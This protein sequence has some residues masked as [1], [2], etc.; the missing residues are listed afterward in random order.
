MTKVN[1]WNDSVF[2]LG[3]VCNRCGEEWVPGS[4][5]CVSCEFTDPRIFIDLVRRMRAAKSRWGYSRDA[6]DLRESKKLERDVDNWLETFDGR[7]P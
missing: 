3:K 1:T 2:P 6:S 7:I 5:R 4:L